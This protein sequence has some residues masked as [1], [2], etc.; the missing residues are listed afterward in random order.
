MVMLSRRHHVS[1]T[2][3]VQKDDITRHYQ[4]FSLGM[5]Y[6]WAT[7]PYEVIDNV[8]IVPHDALNKSFSVMLMEVDSEIELIA[9]P[10]SVDLQRLH[11]HIE[12][13]EASRSEFGRSI[14][15]QFRKGINPTIAAVF[16]VICGVSFFVGLGY[17]TVQVRARD[18]Q[19]A[20]PRDAVRLELEERSEEIAPDTEPGQLDGP[21]P[22]RRP[23]GGRA[24]PQ[25]PQTPRANSAA[26]KLPNRP[27][28][29]RQDVGPA[30]EPR[31]STP[32]VEPSRSAPASQQTPHEQMQPSPRDGF[33]PPGF[34]GPRSIQAMPRPGAFRPSPRQVP[35][36]LRQPGDTELA[37]GSG[38]IPF[39]ATAPNGKPVVGFQYSLGSWAGKKAIRKLEPLFDRNP[40]K[41]SLETVLAREGYAV[42]AIH[43]HAG[44]LV[45]ALQIVFMRATSDGLDPSD[46][47]TSQWICICLK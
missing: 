43:V 8:V 35:A 13:Q 25:S 24:K 46:S 3:H 6:G 11:R 26:P 19:L 20:D 37:G 14:P 44:D 9:I 31:N 23:L 34:G 1:G 4:Y 21:P 7:W 5:W 10:K 30:A 41:A 33:R 45:H 42:G 12:T 18:D 47:Y 16:S 36:A 15:A 32:A 29:S 17:Y 38:G 39:R 28:G 27:P 22:I 40:P 2:V